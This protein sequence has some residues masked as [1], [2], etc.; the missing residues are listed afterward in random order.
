M[1][2][3]G[4]GVEMS[5]LAYEEFKATLA[6]AQVAS[7]NV[8]ASQSTRIRNAEFAERQIAQQEHNAT[9][10]AN[11]RWEW[12]GDFAAAQAQSQ[13]VAAGRGA[14]ADAAYYVK[15]GTK[16]STPLYYGTKLVMK[17]GPTE[18]L[19]NE[20]M[21]LLYGG[22]N[23]DS[24]L[25]DYSRRHPNEHAAPRRQKARRTQRRGPKRS[26]PTE[27]TTRNPRWKR[28]KTEEG[29]NKRARSG[30]LD[31]HEK[32][33]KKWRES[34]GRSAVGYVPWRKGRDHVYRSKGR[35]K[36]RKRRTRYRRRRW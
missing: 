1:S 32:A 28:S 5:W 25:R 29:S 10:R 30:S 34:W 16:Y 13:R 7:E 35:K 4:K 14:G 23:E 15:K 8:L 19:H 18:E 33:R 36:G 21:Y 22:I 24:S 2:W 27:E 3:L 26:Y 17:N 9:M 20:I 31:Q 6:A 12:D 11:G